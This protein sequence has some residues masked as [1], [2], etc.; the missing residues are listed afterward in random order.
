MISYSTLAVYD[1][2]LLLICSGIVVMFRTQTEKNID[3][4]LLI[5][6]FGWFLGDILKLLILAS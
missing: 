4:M 2:V 5:V 1:F 6:I 3:I